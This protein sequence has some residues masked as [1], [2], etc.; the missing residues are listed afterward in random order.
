[1]R[2]RKDRLTHSREKQPTRAGMSLAYSRRRK[3]VWLE[4][5]EREKAVLIKSARRQGTAY[6]GSFHLSLD[7]ILI[8]MGGFPRIISRDKR[9]CVRFKYL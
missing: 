2:K 9:S 3:L 7:F 8:V 6:L 5:N 4:Y 1:M